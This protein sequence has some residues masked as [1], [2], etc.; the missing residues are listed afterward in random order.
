M[1]TIYEEYREAIQ[2]AGAKSFRERMEMGPTTYK[3]GFLDGTK[4]LLE[5]LL[6]QLLLEHAEMLKQNIDAEKS[7]YDF[8]SKRK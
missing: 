3:E 4:Y 1:K 6:P 7:V 5:E 2:E 8:L